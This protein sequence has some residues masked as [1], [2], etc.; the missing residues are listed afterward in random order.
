MSC[1]RRRRIDFVWVDTGAARACRRA[2][3]GRERG[4]V[5]S[6]TLTH[7]TAALGE[8]ASEALLTAREICRG[9]LAPSRF[10]ALLE[11]RSASD[12]V[13]READAGDARQT[14]GQQ[15]DDETNVEHTAAK[16]RPSLGRN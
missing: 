12:P 15:A 5:S 16:R 6:A 2:V 9:A 3:V 14:T 4:L 8:D 7:T 1:I 13:A 11:Y 10:Y